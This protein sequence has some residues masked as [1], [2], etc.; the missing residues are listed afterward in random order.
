MRLNNNDYLAFALLDALAD[1]YLSVTE[2]LGSKIEDIEI[3][4]LDKKGDGIAEKIYKLKTELS[5]LRK[6]V[7]PVKDIILQVYKAEDTFFT[8]DTLKYFRDFQESIIQTNE[9][10]ELYSNLASDQLSMHNTVVSNHMNQ[11]MKVLTIFA[12]LFIPLTFIAGIYGMNF[13]YMPELGFKY[14]YLIFWIVILVVT[15]LLLLFFKRKKW[16]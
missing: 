16:L 15:G 5:Y 2:E 14:S 13:Q 11:V 9:A 8:Q 6:S 12:S 7:R 1:R 3:E 10:I 4:I